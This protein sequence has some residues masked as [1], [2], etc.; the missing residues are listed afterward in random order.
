MQTAAAVG[1]VAIVVLGVICW[2]VVWGELRRPPRF[3][4]NQVVLQR[5][6]FGQGYTVYTLLSTREHWNSIL[7]TLADALAKP[8]DALSL[9]FHEMNGRPD[10]SSRR[11]WT[12]HLTA[13]GITHKIS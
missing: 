6:S 7:Q 5:G 10:P 3:E 4:R 8:E 13:F 1:L 12:E 11:L 9:G 2:R